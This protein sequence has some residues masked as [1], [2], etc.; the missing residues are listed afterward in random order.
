MTLLA[1]TLQAYFTDRLLRQR[2]ASPH[3]VTAYRRA[4]RLLVV[5]AAGQTGKASVSGA[6]V[7]S[8]Q[9]AAETAVETTGTAGQTAQ[10]TTSAAAGAGA[11]VGQLAQTG[12]SEAPLA[13]ALLGA[14][15][16]LIGALLLRPRDF[17]RKLLR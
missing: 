14:M 15:L 13:E 9:T 11:G 12:G 1:P 3:T 7:G 4:W 8:N 6:T 2:Q 17:L 16:A 5:Y 10:A